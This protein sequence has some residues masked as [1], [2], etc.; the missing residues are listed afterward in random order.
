MRGG[1]MEA[2]RETVWEALMGW[3]WIIVAILAGGDDD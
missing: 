2:Q 3:F 1:L